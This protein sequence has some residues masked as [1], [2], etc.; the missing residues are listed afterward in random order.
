MLQSISNSGI[1]IN[2]LFQAPGL[3]NKQFLLDWLHIVDLGVAADFMGNV[4]HNLIASGRHLPGNNVKER[5]KSLFHKIQSYYKTEGVENKLPT[6]T[7]LMI[8]KKTS[9]SPKLRAKTAETRGLIIFAKQICDEFFDDD[10]VLEY[11]IKMAATELWQCYFFWSKN[12][13]NHRSMLL[14]GRKFLLLR[15]SLENETD[16]TWK[17]K[18]K[19]HSFLDLLLQNSCPSDFG[20]FLAHLGAVKGGSHNPYSIGMSVL[21]SFRAQVI[22]EMK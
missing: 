9:S 14:H 15:K 4:F 7:V 6:L 5:V 21:Q 10:N 1:D 17:I 8:R 22:P 3:T 12:L 13:W 11:T 16:H 19:H 18:P 20:G 2:E